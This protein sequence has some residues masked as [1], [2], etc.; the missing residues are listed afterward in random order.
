MAFSIPHTFPSIYFPATKFSLLPS[1]YFSQMASLKPQRLTGVGAEVSC[2][3]VTAATGVVTKGTFEGLFARVELDMTQ[4]VALL[5][6]GGPTLVTLEWPLT[7]RDQDYQFSHRRKKTAA[8]IFKLTFFYIFGL[9]LS[10]VSEKALTCM[11]A[12]MHH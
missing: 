2:Q 7:Y 4:Q 10:R 6:E 8:H 11:A 12:F 1:L 5:S 9:F 3:G